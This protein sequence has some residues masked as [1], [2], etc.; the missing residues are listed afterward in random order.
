MLEHVNSHGPTD[1]IEKSQLTVER[2]HDIF[3]AAYMKPEI[4]SDGDLII[5]GRTRIRYIVQVRERQGIIAIFGIFGFRD[6]AEN[7][8]KLE[9]VN[10]LNDGKVVVRFSVNRRGALFIDYHLLIEEG[11]SPLQI[12]NCFTRFDSVVIGSLEEIKDL[13]G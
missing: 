6:G 7:T 11:V 1:L 5:R 9:A 8:E 10:K 2:L 3:Q 12:L 13:L 4:D